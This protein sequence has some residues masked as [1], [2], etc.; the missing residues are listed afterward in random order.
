M[1]LRHRRIANGWIVVGILTALA[2]AFWTE[3][4]G[5]GSV[6]FGRQAGVLLLVCFPLFCLGALGGGDVKALSLIGGVWGVE[7]GLRVLGLSLLIGA[8]VGLVKLLYQ[9]RMGERMR[10]LFF[11]LLRQEEKKEGSYWMEERDGYGMTVA[12]GCC[13]FVGMLLLALLS[14]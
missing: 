3:G 13:I 12:F 7:R 9:G 11:Y 14:R 5:R 10:Y 8:G 2:V 1:D 6:L 4:L